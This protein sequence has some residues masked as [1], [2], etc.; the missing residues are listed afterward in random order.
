MNWFLTCILVGFIVS[1]DGVYQ[2][3]KASY[4]AQSMNGR[5]TASGERYCSDSLTAAHAHLPFGTRVSVRNLKNDSIVTLRI[6]DRMA[7]SSTR[8]IDVSWA[9]AKKLNFVRD[10]LAQVE[11]SILDTL[12]RQ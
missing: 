3:G 4:Y 2:R 8:I 1:T 10:G 11:L 7:S 9:A 5:R 12:K 6:I